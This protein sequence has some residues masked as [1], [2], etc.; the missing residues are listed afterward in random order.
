MKYA[1]SYEIKLLKFKNESKNLFDTALVNANYSKT[2]KKTKKYLLK[3]DR[4]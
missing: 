1:I 2:E 3:E 4:F